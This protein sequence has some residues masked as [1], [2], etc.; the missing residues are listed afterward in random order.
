MGDLIYSL[1]VVKNT[2]GGNFYLHLNQMDWIGQH[3]YGAAPNPFHQGR[4]TEQDFEFMQDF[5]LAQTYI[6]A[7]QILDP[8]TAEISHNLDRF[9]APFVQHPCNYLDLYA[10]IHN[11]DPNLVY[12]P[13]L[14]VPTP[15]Q[16]PGRPIV[17]NRTQRWTNP[18]GLS[19]WHQLHEQGQDRQAL[20]VGLPKEYEQFVQDTG[21]TNILYWPTANMLE[22]ASIIAGSDRFI[23]NQSQCYALAVGLGIQNIHLELRRDL[24]L[25]RN[26]CYFPKFTQIQYF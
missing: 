9:R 7:F 20:F 22:L 12:R 2:G 1:M 13:W 11:V 16:V 14:T 26:E 17:V 4:L 15:I 6:T 21:W 3:Y 25:D 8:Q 19:V 24:P 23:G 10:Q 5:M 18:A